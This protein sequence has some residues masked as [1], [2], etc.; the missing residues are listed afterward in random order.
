MLINPGIELS[1]WRSTF[2]KA[3]NAMQRLTGTKIVWLI[4]MFLPLVVLKVLTRLLGTSAGVVGFFIAS[5][6]ALVIGIYHWR[7]RQGPIVPLLMALILTLGLVGLLV[8]TQ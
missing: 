1:L 5:G 4:S 2:N 6:I 8:V 7:V 3:H